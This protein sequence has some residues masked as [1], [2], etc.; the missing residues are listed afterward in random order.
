MITAQSSNSAYEVSEQGITAMIFFFRQEGIE[1]SIRTNHHSTPSP[2]LKWIKKKK[3][4]TI[5]IAYTI[6]TIGLVSSP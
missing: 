1:Y 2:D 3:K 5:F 6:S 4:N